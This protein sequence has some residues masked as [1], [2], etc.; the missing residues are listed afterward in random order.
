MDMLRSYSSAFSRSNITDILLYDDYSYLDWLIK[1]YNTKKYECSYLNYLKALYT[2]L[3]KDYR[4]EYVYKNELIHEL[5]KKYGTKNTT[6]YNEFKVGDSIADIAFFNGESKAFEIKTEYDTSKRLD[7]QL[8][9]YSRVFDKC[10]IVIPEE[11]LFDYYDI[12]DEK[13]GI[14][15]VKRIGRRFMLEEF[16]PAV[17]NEYIAKDLFMSC[18]RTTEYE[19]LIIDKFGSL[20]TAKPGHL[21]KAC[22]EQINKLSN[23]DLKQYFINTIKTRRNNAKTLYQMPHSLRQTCLALNLNA[24]KSQILL[25]K[26]NKPINYVLSVS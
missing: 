1:R 26:L 23:E 14:I 15:L 4:C 24:T 25:E 10:Y 7:K 9:S 6:V 11:K 12:R 20:P 18:L 8:L 17:E 16:R 21:F 3:A 2:C 5:L 22:F 13:T 19:D